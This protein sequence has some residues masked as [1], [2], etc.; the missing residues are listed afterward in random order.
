MPVERLDVWAPGGAE[1]GAGARLS[2]GFND[3]LFAA[4]GRH[5][6]VLKWAREHGC[7]WNKRLF[8]LA[9]HNHPETLP[10]ARAQ[11]E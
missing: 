8:I 3:A 10:W 4:E 1:V 7:P 11:P 9:S 5:L 6:E 2:L